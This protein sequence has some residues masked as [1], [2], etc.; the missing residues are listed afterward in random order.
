MSADDKTLSSSGNV[1]DTNYMD[2]MS[3]TT[4]KQVLALG[5]Y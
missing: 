1:A 4:T 3:L 2:V 5:T